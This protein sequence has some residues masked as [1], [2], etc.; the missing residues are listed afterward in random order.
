MAH[1]PHGPVSDIHDLFGKKKTDPKL[2]GPYHTDNHDDAHGSH[3]WRDLAYGVSAHTPH[4]H[5][6]KDVKG[7]PFS[8]KNLWGC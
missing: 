6:V 1:R 7:S 8:G 2:V 5:D 4:G 3:D